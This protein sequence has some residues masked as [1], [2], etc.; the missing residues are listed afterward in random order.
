MLTSLAFA[1]APGHWH[2]NDLAPLSKLYADSSDRLRE[3]LV[4]REAEGQA[5]AQAI[6]RYEEALDLLGGDAPAAEREHHAAL[7]DDFKEMR[8]QVQSFADTLVADYDAAFRRAIA[9]AAGPPFPDLQECE[10]RMSTGPTMPGLPSDSEPNPACEGE[11]LN[12]TLAAKADA[13]PRLK[14]DLD[15]IVARPWP[16]ITVA[17]Q[18]RPVLGGE[19][20]WVSLR[21][22]VAAVAGDALSGI[23]ASDALARMELSSQLADLGDDPAALDALR[24]KAEQ[25]DAQTAASRAAI[26]GPVLSAA[27]AALEKRRDDPPIG[28]CVYPELL[29]GCAGEE[30]GGVVEDLARNRKGSGQTRHWSGHGFAEGATRRDMVL[31]H[32]GGSPERW[33]ELPAGELGEHGEH[34]DDAAELV[35]ALGAGRKVDEVEHRRDLGSGAHGDAEVVAAGVS[36]PPSGA[37]RDV[38][39]HRVRGA[40][41]LVAEVLAVGGE[42]LRSRPARHADRNPVVNEGRATRATVRESERRRSRTVVRT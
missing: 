33:G 32:P 21:D 19:P 11:N 8:L 16:T 28:W 2:P 30:A 27:R 29:G 14:A 38:E 41:H 34:G 24:V 25:I 13:D 37:F 22:V 12:A 7:E 10:A 42:A 36:R 6:L 18:P 39:H 23:E 15:E 26:G 40:D 3:V 9:R 35:L 1:E 5:L 20:R 31:S 4:Q 17:A